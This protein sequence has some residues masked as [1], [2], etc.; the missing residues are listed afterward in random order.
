MGTATTF[1]QQVRCHYYLHGSGASLTADISIAHV[2]HI[3]R[4][5]WRPRVAGDQKKPGVYQLATCSEDGTLRLIRIQLQPV[6]Q[7]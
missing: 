3:H 7:A 2:K 5:T 4:M 6:T 1:G